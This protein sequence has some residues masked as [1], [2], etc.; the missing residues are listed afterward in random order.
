[1]QFGCGAGQGILANCDVELMN[2][3]AIVTNQALDDCSRDPGF[4][5]Q[6]RSGTPDDTA[7]AFLKVIHKTA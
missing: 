1:L 3:L 2:F 4:V 5:E 6:G 7:M